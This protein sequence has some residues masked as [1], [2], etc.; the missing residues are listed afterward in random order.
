MGDRL[1][2]WTGAYNLYTHCNANYGGY[3]D[4]RTISPQMIE[5]L[6]LLAYDSGAGANIADVLDSSSS[7]YNELALVYNP[8]V[9]VQ[10]RQ[11]VSDDTRPLRR[12]GG[13]RPDVTGRRWPEEQRPWKRVRCR[14]PGRRAHRRRRPA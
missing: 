3:N 11:G 6:Q 14:R 9:K 7:A 5:F 4:I 1:W 10:Q 13:V 8:D 2:D 12:T